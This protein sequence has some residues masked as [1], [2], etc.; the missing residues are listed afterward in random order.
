[1]AN[2]RVQDTARERENTKGKVNIKVLS[3]V[4]FQHK[5]LEQL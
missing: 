5:L 4:F 2:I 3:K 1:M